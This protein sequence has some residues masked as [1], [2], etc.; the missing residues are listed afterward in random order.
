MKH[1][2][3][4]CNVTDIKRLGKFS[5]NKHRTLA[6]KIESDYVKRLLLLSLRKLK[7]HGKPVFI[8]KKLNLE[9]QAK[10]N[11]LLQMRRTNI[12]QGTSAKSLG[13]QN[14]VIQKLTDKN[15]VDPD[16]NE[17]ENRIELDWLSSSKVIT[18]PTYN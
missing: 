17:N 11:E 3:V 10:E 6:V 18:F 13:I 4:F 9:E 14:L 15:W 7:D 2:K 1:L 16:S 8:T 12:N 5:E